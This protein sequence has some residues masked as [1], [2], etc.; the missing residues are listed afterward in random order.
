MHTLLILF[1]LG[2]ALGGSLL[3]ASLLRLTRSSRSRRALQGAGLLLPAVVLGLL[4]SVMV[5]FLSQLCFQ[6]APRLDA[7]VAQTLSIIG[8]LGI[9]A[10]ITLNGTRAV[11]LPV[12][13]RRHTWQAPA[14]LET[15]IAQ[16]VAGTGLRY[17]PRARVAADPRPWALVAGVFKPHLVVSSGLVALLDSEELEAVLCHEL[18]HI[19]RGDL[20]WTAIGGVL[21]DLTWFLPATRRLYRLLLTEQEV[22]CDDGVLGEPRRLALASALARVWQAE[23]SQG[24][25]GAAPRGALAL[26]SPDHSARLEARVRRLLDHPGIATISTSRR[27]LLVVA[28]V[29]G[30]LVPAQLLAT[31]LTMS[32][33][34]CGIYGFLSTVIQT[35]IH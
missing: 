16:L 28:A 2:L 23:I 33:M 12:H 27:G 5:H 3:C 11:L 9:M 18:L 10:A 6:M 30:L 19:H 8:A 4:T 24:L 14:W 15:R 1:S 34:G 29:L 22:A 13:L 20:W 31:L 21:R 32:S 35:A 17:A 26:S 7:A 25:A